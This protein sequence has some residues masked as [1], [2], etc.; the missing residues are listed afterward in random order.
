MRAIGD[1]RLD[2]RHVFARFQR[3]ETADTPIRVRRHPEIRP[4]N[5]TMPIC[6]NISPCKVLAY[7]AQVWRPVAYADHAAHGIGLAI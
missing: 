4:M 7:G 6:V 5:M 3:C 1:Q 2:E